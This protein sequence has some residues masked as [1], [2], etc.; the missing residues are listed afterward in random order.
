MVWLKTSAHLARA[1]EVSLIRIFHP[2]LLRIDLRIVRT[3]ESLGHAPGQWR[4][5]AKQSCH[6]ASEAR[7]RDATVCCYVRWT[8]P[9]SF[10]STI[11]WRIF[12]LACDRRTEAAGSR[13]QGSRPSLRGILPLLFRWRRKQGSL[14]GDN[15]AG[16]DVNR[17]RPVSV[18]RRR[19]RIRLGLRDCC[20]DRNSRNESF[21]T[22][23]DLYILSG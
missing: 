13:A 12:A 21:P 4:A 15:L 10:A 19:L 7:T 18:L 3:A 1:M 23:S 17:K 14:E 6:R 11:E 2:I 9:K 20:Q 8:H 16:S 22:G 5:R